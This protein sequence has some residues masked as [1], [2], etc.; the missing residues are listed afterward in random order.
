[1]K[2]Q[3]PFLSLSLLLYEVG[4]SGL[5]A[6]GTMIL[7]ILI[8]AKASLSIGV[9]RSQ[10]V[11]Y[12]DERTKIIG[13]VLLG[14][15]VVKM[16]NWEEAVSDRIATIRSKEMELIAK[17]QFL[18]ALNNIFQYIG[19]LLI[20]FSFFICYVAIGGQL[21]VPFVYKISAIL[22]IFRMPLWLTPI[23]NRNINTKINTSNNYLILISIQIRRM[24]KFVRSV[25]IITKN[26]QVSIARRNW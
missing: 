14:I 1:M 26:K 10:L 2:L 4:L 16:Y 19:P 8:Q 5:V 20:S 25:D 9:V 18:K 23:G 15:R 6:L 17:L 24:G 11:K 7:V 13:E 22:N 3:I 21:T 12:T